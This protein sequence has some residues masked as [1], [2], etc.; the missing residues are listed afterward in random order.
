MS[1]E[2]AYEM[3]AESAKLFGWQISDCDIFSDM[4][5]QR[6]IKEPIH[7]LLLIPNGKNSLHHFPAGPPG[8]VSNIQ[9]LLLR[10]SLPSLPTAAPASPAAAPCPPTPAGAPKVEPELPEPGPEPAAAEAAPNVEPEPAAAHAAPQSQHLSGPPSP[11]KRPLSPSPQ[12][13]PNKKRM[14]VAADALNSSAERW[15]RMNRTHHEFYCSTCD[16]D[17]NGAEAYAT[18]MAGKFHKNRLPIANRGSPLARSPP[19]VS[20]PES[21]STV[22]RSPGSRSPT[23]DQLL[24]SPCPPTRKLEPAPQTPPVE[25]HTQQALDEMHCMFHGC[26]NRFI[27]HVQ[28]VGLIGLFLEVLLNW[29]LNIRAHITGMQWIS[30]MKSDVGGVVAVS[31]SAPG[32]KSCLCVCAHGTK[33]DVGTST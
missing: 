21:P 2:N 15:K 11:F 18:H 9:H 4:W 7:G 10:S 20:P 29:R 26:I 24:F 5:A 3:M 30:E 31:E 1:P 8:G 16:L 33:M 27:Y 23:P 13:G 22:A 14:K 25:K 32:I 12:P 28:F 17:L 6:N 19:P